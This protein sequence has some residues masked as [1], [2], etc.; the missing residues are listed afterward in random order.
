VCDEAQLHNEIKSNER[1]QMKET[2][3]SEL[4]LWAITSAEG[5]GMCY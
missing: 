5:R 1:V 4:S 3:N 2:L